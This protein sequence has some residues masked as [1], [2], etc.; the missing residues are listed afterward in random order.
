MD[1]NVD[2]AM[3]GGKINLRYDELKVTRVKHIL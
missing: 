2:R 3:R 1:T